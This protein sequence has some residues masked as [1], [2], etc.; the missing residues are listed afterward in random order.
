MD[1][2]VIRNPGIY[3]WRSGGEKHINDPASIAS[4]QVTNTFPNLKFCYEIYKNIFF[5]LIF[6]FFSIRI[7]LF[8]R[9]IQLTRTIAGPRWK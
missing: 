7:M 3:H 1:M 8:P 6:V 4:L 5:F 2:L 9:T